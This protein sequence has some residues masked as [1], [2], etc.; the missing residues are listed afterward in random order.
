MRDRFQESF[1][2]VSLGS[3]DLDG[4]L[5][6][7]S[8]GK[9]FGSSSN[10][11]LSVIDDDS[12]EAKSHRNICPDGWK[13]LVVG[14]VLS[15]LTAGIICLQSFM[16]T[17]YQ[18]SA[19]AFAGMF[20]YLLRCFYLIPLYNISSNVKEQRWNE[21]VLYKFCGCF[22][23]VHPFWWHLFVALLSVEAWYVTGLA[24][25]YTAMT[26]TTWLWCLF[27]MFTAMMFTRCILLSRKYSWFQLMAATL[28]TIGVLLNVGYL[29]QATAE[30]DLQEIRR[31]TIS[32]Y[33]RLGQQI[34]STVRRKTSVA[35]GEL[36][37]S[38]LQ[39]PHHLEGNLL[40][41]LAGVLSGIVQVSTEVMIQKSSVAEFMGVG[42]LLGLLISAIQAA[43]LERQAT[44]DFFSESGS[45]VGMLGLLL[46]L[47][48]ILVYSHTELAARFFHCG[49][50]VSQMEV[51]MSSAG[52]YTTIVA[53]VGANVTQPSPFFWA[54]L[55]AIVSGILLYH[56]V[57][58][59]RP[60]VKVIPE[61]IEVLQM[62]AALKE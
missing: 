19:P 49:W 21:P 28:C 34:F 39:F 45:S 16:Y 7:S 18:L 22:R 37:V 29:I 8:R 5:F 11:P 32:T 27:S 41:I 60:T 56:S 40:A 38:A 55:V 53:I 62:E 48:V 46:I 58:N 44:T 24:C 51:S 9:S 35:D 57:P 54:G 12:S 50:D 61:S 23:L 17:K 42:G 33:Q 10:R 47:Y 1:L 26:A 14:Q 31:T 59:N 6:L 3:L 4:S 13:P 30:G 36:I 15:I 25:R 2:S 43:V 52:V 20:V